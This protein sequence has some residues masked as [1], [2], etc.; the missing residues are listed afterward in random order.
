VNKFQ[1]IAASSAHSTVVIVTAVASTSPELI[2]FATAVPTSAPI[3]FQNAAQI[4]ATRGVS[5][6]VET[7]VAMAF[8]VS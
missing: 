2:V 5:T 8:A 6:L 7:T 3:R 1:T 4:T